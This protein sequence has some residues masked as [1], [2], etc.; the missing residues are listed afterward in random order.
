MTLTIDSADGCGF[1]NETHPELLLKNSFYNKR[2]FI[3]YKIL[4]NR[5]S[6][7]VIKA[8]KQAFKKFYHES[9]EDQ[10]TPNT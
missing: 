3:S 9:S 1:S 7:S 6:V 10:L 5:L 8:F 2:H 4:K